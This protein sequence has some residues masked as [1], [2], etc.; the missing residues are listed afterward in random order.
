M[1]T[2]TT[3]KKAPVR[4]LAAKKVTSTSAKGS[5]AVAINSAP[6][7]TTEQFWTADDAAFFQPYFDKLKK[8]GL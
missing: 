2:K 3:A 1:A 8:A 7:P 6:E 5:K 4:K